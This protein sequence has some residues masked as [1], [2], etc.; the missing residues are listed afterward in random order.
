MVD[1]IARLGVAVD[2]TS[3]VS[4]QKDLEALATAGDKSTASVKKLADGWQS[5]TFANSKLLA[6]NKGLREFR[7]KMGEAG[8]ASSDLEAE[9]K[10]NTFSSSRLLSLNQDLAK[11]KQ[12]NLEAAKAAAMVDQEWKKN[13]FSNAQLMK[14][15]QSLINFRRETKAAADES[16]A[17]AARIVAANKVQAESHHQVAK[18]Q[19]GYVKSAKEMAFATRNLPAQ[20][21]D[22]AVSLQAGQNPLTVLLQQGG[23]LKDMFGGVGPAIRAMGGY[24][25]G[26][27]S[28]LTLAAAGTAALAVA[29][30]KGD[31]EGRRFQTTVTMSGNSVRA[32]ADDLILASEQMERFGRS[33]GAAADALNQTAASGKV[34]GSNIRVVAEAA[35]NMERSAGQAIEKT[36]EQFASLAGEPLQAAI[37]LDEQYHF[38]TT[39]VYENIKA[40][41]DQGD[42]MGATQA[43]TDALAAVI[44]QRSQEIESNLGTLQH[45]WRGVGMV[46]KWAWDQ[47]MD[48]GRPDSLGAK[49]QDMGSK[50]AEI[51]N[52]SN[53]FSFAQLGPKGSAA[54]K[55]AAEDLRKEMMALQDKYVSDQKELAKRTDEQIA[56]ESSRRLDQEV[57]RYA[58]NA[59]Q[60]RLQKARVAATADKAVE[61]E[62]RLRSAGYVK[63]IEEIRRD[64]A[65]AIAGIDKRYADPKT[66]KAK[67]TEEARDAERLLKQR[68]Q[69]YGNLD[70]ALDRHAETLRAAGEAEDKLSSFERYAVKTLSDLKNGHSLLLPAQQAEIQAR[71][72]ALRVIDQQN[73]KRDQE[74]KILRVSA[75]LS[76][77]I[78]QDEAAQARGHSRDLLGVGRGQNEGALEMALEDIRYRAQQGKMDLEEKYQNLRAEGTAAHLADL[79]KI[80]EAEARMSAAEIAQYERR[81]AAMADWRNGARSAME[82]IAYEVNNTAGQT[83]DG[84]MNIWGAMNSAVD[85]FARTGKFKIRD[86]ATTVIAE[87]LRIALTIAASKFLTSMFGAGMDAGGGGSMPTTGPTMANGGVFGGGGVIPFAKGGVTPFAM[88]GVNGTVFSGATLLPMANGSTALV[89]EERPEAVLPLQRG[90][91]GKLG[92]ASSGG[93]GA[94]FNINT[95]VMVDNNG[96]AST[97]TDAN[98]GN[99]ESKMLG[100]LLT[101]R[102][103]EVLVQERR[104]GGLLWQMANG[105]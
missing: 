91:N 35:L 95:T 19:V 68:A 7:E 96:N 101:N 82:D 9:W 20:F 14:A 33:Q 43:A 102:I 52:P 69:E 50:L 90:A 4:A 39:T 17:G 94:V 16:A 8:K 12:A 1:E 34:F 22:I 55:K 5:A 49:M 38:L 64:E 58:S 45:A 31:A 2:S 104:Q 65:A 59:D 53:M 36:V 25:A 10:K 88:G 89:G 24:V 13:T 26:L 27:I 70:Q 3:A 80:N 41:E 86:F 74:N 83:R 79:A 73:Q 47:M 21:T 93:G 72:E 87:L 71:I 18:A 77:Q 103:R 81:K 40:L 61:A 99:Q 48:V 54:R 28:P 44:D 76:R 30:I 105:R 11:F 60:R 98:N 51:E 92:V 78:A 32:T 42:T 63:R 37:K 62:E 84:F 66:P 56:A 85:N 100:E 29:W 75:E 23:Q 97:S 46:A 15:N 67:K 6:A 57:R